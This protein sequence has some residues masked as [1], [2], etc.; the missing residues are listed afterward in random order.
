MRSRSL[1]LEIRARALSVEQHAATAF[2]LLRGVLQIGGGKVA[3]I[4]FRGVRIVLCKQ[5]KNLGRRAPWQPEQRH[6]AS[7][8]HGEPTK[9]IGRQQEKRDAGF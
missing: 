7:S 9:K 2:H 4:S 1:V 3:E 5:Q 6:R 8:S